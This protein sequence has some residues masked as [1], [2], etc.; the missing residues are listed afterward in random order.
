[1]TPQIL[2][3]PGLLGVALALCLVGTPSNSGTLRY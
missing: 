3:L 1:M 2:L